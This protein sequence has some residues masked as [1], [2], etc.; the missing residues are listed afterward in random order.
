M[1]KSRE[2]EARSTYPMTMGKVSANL[3][4]EW[5]CRARELCPTRRSRSISNSNSQ[6][7][8]LYLSTLEGLC[9][10][11]LYREHVEPSVS[12]VYWHSRSRQKTITSGLRPVTLVWL[13]VTDLPTPR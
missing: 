2:G 11:V 7:R 6:T 5:R 1:S 13:D 9:I 10:I 8:A 12:Y 3:S 4:L